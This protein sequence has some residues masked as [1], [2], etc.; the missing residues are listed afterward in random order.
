MRR[1]NLVA[2]TDLDLYDEFDC[3]ASVVSIEA[4]IQQS[5]C[6]GSQRKTSLVEATASM[7]ALTTRLCHPGGT[8]TGIDT[9]KRKRRRRGDLA[10]NPALWAALGEGV[11][12]REILTDFYRRVYED[13]LLAPFFEGVTLDRAIGKQYSFLAQIFTGERIYFGER[14]RNAH[15]WMV[16]GDELFDYREALIE[17]C[18]RCW[19]LADEHVRAWLGVHQVFRKQIV[20]ARPIP[21]KVRGVA[22]PLEGYER[23]RVS[24]GSLCDGC[25]H[26]IES[27]EQTA[28]H[29]RTGRMYCNQCAPNRQQEET[30]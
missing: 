26:T 7:P 16:I 20:K 13:P 9:G 17:D 14:P 5:R 27:G 10:P 3:S 28:Y 15:H 12:L 23:M 11:G 18:M 8:L 19:G 30:R 29:V 24:I 2:G 21:K 25:E 6:R 4:A 1:A 22:L